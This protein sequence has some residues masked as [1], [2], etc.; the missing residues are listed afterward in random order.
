MAKE[1]FP[2]KERKKI[3][4]RLGVVVILGLAIYLILPQ[5]TVLTNSLQIVEA[6]LF[7]AVIL[8][9]IAQVLSYFGSGYLLQK[10]LA[11]AQEGVSLVRSTLIVLG[12]ASI[13]IVAGGLVGSSAAIYHWTRG[14]GEDV[15]GATLASLLPSLFNDFIL[16]LFSIIGLTYLLAIRHLDKAQ[17]IGFS[18]ILAI[19]AMIFLIAVL[20][21]RYRDRTVAIFDRIELLIG[22]LLRRKVDISNVRKEVDNLFDAWEI[23]WHSGWHL[24]ALGAFLNVAFDML[25][26]YFMFVASGHIVGF[27]VLIA[28]YGLPILLGKIAFILPSGLGVVETSMAALYTGLG[29]PGAV[30]VVVVLGYRLISFWIPSISGFP[31]AAYLQGRKVNRPGK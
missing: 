5:I 10:T 13:S 3:W 15:E 21:M 12:A 7:W 24:L 8:A 14:E 18:I 17:V 25:T 29:V 19:L 4:Q 23:L 31:I 9:F 26:L 6:M 2:S 30:A 1:L 20:A 27:G 22:R 11:I 16:V 28:G